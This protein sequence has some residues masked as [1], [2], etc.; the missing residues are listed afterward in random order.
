MKIK[1]KMER[2]WLIKISHIFLLIPLLFILF[3]CVN[4]TNEGCD[5]T[6]LLK[7][8]LSAEDDIKFTQNEKNGSR[9]A[10][11]EIPTLYYT[12]EAVKTGSSERYFGV[13]NN[14]ERTFEIKLTTGEWTLTA[15]GYC[16]EEKNKQSFEGMTKVNLEKLQPVVDDIT[17]TVKPQKKG[18]G[19]VNLTLNIDENCGI[20]TCEAEWK[21]GVTTQTQTLDFSSNTSATFTMNGNG[22]DI[23]SNSYT[24]F[25]KFYSKDKSELLYYC[26][27][28]VNVFDNLTT[29]TWVNN[30]NKLYLSEDTEGKTIF[31]ITDSLIE[32]FKMT[33]FF[34]QG[35][36][37][38]Y[39]PNISS[40][41][42]NNGTYFDPLATVAKAAQ[43]SADRSKTTPCYIFIDGIVTEGEITNIEEYSTIII[44]AFSPN[45]E[46][47]KAAS[48]NPLIS[49]SGSLTI[50][51]IKTNGNLTY[52]KGNLTLKGST[53]LDTISLDSEGLLITIDEL[54]SESVA[55]ITMKDEN[56]P[57]SNIIYKKGDA[58]L[59]P[60]DTK[61]L[62]QTDCNRFS[63]TSPYFVLMPN[64][65]GTKGI[66]ADS[67]GKI[68]PEIKKEVLF[69]LD[70][71]GEVP[72]YS[73]GETI[74][75][76]AV[77]TDKSITA[78]CTDDMTDW[79]IVIT[80]HGSNTGTESTTNS[81]TIPDGTTEI[82]KWPADTY[83]V[84]VSAKYKTD[85]VVYDA[86]F[87]IQVIEEKKLF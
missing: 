77:L 86:S 59:K 50:D 14:S 44:M 18:N 42:S 19:S 16:D 72:E 28:T 78:D 76:S 68:I 31:K 38:S 85:N 53:T 84:T 79:K 29:D 51:N 25:L 1:M 5:E 9:T 52:S 27:E 6:I 65:D 60:L 71:D 41:D 40:S 39:T 66:L 7:G 75:V 4:S 30:G 74:T 15:K 17:I 24:V 48:I 61:T 21:N 47:K 55:K 80:N 70:K 32:N 11:P 22:T 87:D 34:V 81:V 67:E 58:I 49:T 3:S 12:V 35:T 73:L 54:S 46:I 8:I 10:F 13:V 20:T 82:K 83:T 23:S 26:I 56:E 43:K 69:T 36:D 37:G 33:S 64:N 2:K 62:T 45:A 63:L 57:Y